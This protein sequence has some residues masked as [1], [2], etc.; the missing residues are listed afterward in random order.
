MMINTTNEIDDKKKSL[1]NMSNCYC[2][3]NCYYLVGIDGTTANGGL[4]GTY[5]RLKKDRSPQRQTQRQPTTSLLLAPELSESPVQMLDVATPSTLLKQTP[6]VALTH[7][8]HRNQ[9][10]H[11]APV[12][13]NGGLK[14]VGDLYDDFN[15]LDLDPKQRK[16]IEQ[17]PRYDDFNCLELEPKQRKLIEQQPRYDDFNCTELEPKQRQQIEQQRYDDFNCLELDPKQRQ[18]IEKQHQQSGPRYYNGNNNN[19]VASSHLPTNYLVQAPVKQSS[20]HV[21]TSISGLYFFCSI[22][23]LFI[24]I[25]KITLFYLCYHYRFFSNNTSYI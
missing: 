5:G 7:N 8:H 6:D 23:Y 14:P 2:V 21:I 13:I 17:Q 22:F 3:N 19:I 16:Q 9:N 10:H 4:N 11:K 12:V 25:L 1:A 18:Q 24:I 20:N 15:C